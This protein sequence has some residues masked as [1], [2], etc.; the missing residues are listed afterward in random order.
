M[1]SGS[2]APYVPDRGDIVYLDFSPHLGREQGRKRP[3][4]ILSPLKYNRM[5]SL[6]LMCPITSQSKGLLFEVPL[7]EGMQTTGVV[8]SDQIKSFDWKARQVKFI[9][10][11]PEDLVEE[12]LAKVETLLS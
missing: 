6:A 3:G 4:I 11:A 2:Q 7:V 8:L 5:A 1:K 9:E 10:K 12:V